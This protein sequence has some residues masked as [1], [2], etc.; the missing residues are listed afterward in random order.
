MM[1]LGC[2]TTI[3]FFKLWHLLQ[4]NNSD[5][6]L[7]RGRCHFRIFVFILD[8]QS[9]SFIHY[10]SSKRISTYDF[11]LIAISNRV[12]CSPRACVGFIQVFCFTPESDWIRF[13]V[14]PPSW[15]LFVFVVR[16]SN[17]TG[18]CARARVSA[19]QMLQLSCTAPPL[20]SPVR[21]RAKSPPTD[22][23][24]AAWTGISRDTPALLQ[25]A[26]R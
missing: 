26:P 12:A 5:V 3:M 21:L 7:N 22:R 9:L 24:S 16:V 11:F 13:M 14:I 1:I 4:F 23:P 20:F 17:S 25:G 19:Q 2:L 10:T 15:T 18:A 6:E 8:C